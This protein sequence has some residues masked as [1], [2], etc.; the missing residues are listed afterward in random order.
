MIATLPSKLKFVSIYTQIATVVAQAKQSFIVE[1]RIL[2][3]V[4]C[5]LGIG[6]MWYHI[7][8]YRSTSLPGFDIGFILNI[9][10]IVLLLLYGCCANWVNETDE[11][12]RGPPSPISRSELR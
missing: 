12:Y 11:V 3:F 9:V 5:G 7:K 10:C 4:G 8:F 1:A 2:A 6:E